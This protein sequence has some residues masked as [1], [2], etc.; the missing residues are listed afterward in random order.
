MQAWFS[1]MVLLRMYQKH[2]SFSCMFGNV[3][4]DCLGRHICFLFLQFLF[5]C[6]FEPKISK[7]V[8]A[9]LNIFYDFLLRQS[10][11]KN[12]SVE[13]PGLREKLPP[14]HGLAGKTPLEIMAACSQKRMPSDGFMNRQA[15]FLSS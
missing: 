4:S 6:F 8:F 7:M 3:F 10:Y 15:G 13:I 14:D 9:F 1:V 5:S 2:L 11:M 12:G